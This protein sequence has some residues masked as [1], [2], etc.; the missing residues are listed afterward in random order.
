MTSLIFDGI[1]LLPKQ[2]IDLNDIQNYIFNKSGI[3]MKVI[4]KPFK[5]YY[6]QLGISNVN[7]QEYK[8]RY[9]NKIYI[10]K[11]V[12]HHLHYKSK[13]NIAG[14][15]CGNCNLKIKNKNELVILFH[16]SK[17]YE[18]NYLI[19][20]FIEIENIRINCIGENNDKFKMLQFRIPE[21]KY[22]I[23]VID[24][25]SFLSG[26]LEELGKDLE[27]DKKILL[28]SHFKSEFKLIINKL[29]NFPYNYVRK[30]NLH[31]ENIPDKSEF[32]NILTMKKMTN[33]E[34]NDVKHF[35]KLMKFKNLKEYLECYLT[36]DILL[37]NDIFHNFRK[38]IF[39]KFQIDCVKYISASS[40][41]KD[42]CFKYTNSK[43]ETIQDISIYN[44]IKHSI[45]GGLSDS[46][47]PRVKLDNDNQTIS[48]VDIN[49]MYPHSLRKKIPVGNYKFI[50]I[51]KFDLSKY[52]ENS[53]YNC[54]MLCEVNTTDIIK[55]DHLYSQ[56]PMLVSKVKVTDKDL[57][58]YQ[59]NQIK[60]KMI[61][62]I[63]IHL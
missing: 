48:Y 53:E 12:I 54:F 15:I 40:L 37:L 1:I 44:F 57:S 39:D 2:Q 50:D 55:N 19:N 26:K 6:P 52:S 46:I 30:D 31:E 13:D 17:G 33:K 60:E 36:V 42:C 58:E 56:C 34:Y 41:T 20:T 38:M 27:N 10:N 21:K 32:Y 29:P 59:L 3:P 28:K 8:E 11:K 22:L 9:K 16:N 62:Q 5:D 23:K 4:M 24:S 63:I 61:I 35:Y 51:Q 14:Y 18:N 43:I 49:S 25:L 7:L 45:M 47:C